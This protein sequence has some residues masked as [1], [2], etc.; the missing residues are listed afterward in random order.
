[1]EGGGGR[2]G[3][4]NEHKVIVGGQIGGVVNGRG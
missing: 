1:M 3:G 2:G 4:Q